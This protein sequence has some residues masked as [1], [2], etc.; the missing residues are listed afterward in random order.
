V[1][2]GTYNPSYPSCF[3]GIFMKHL[4][5]LSLVL[6]LAAC[7]TT[8]QPPGNGDGN[9]DGNGS[10]ER[11]LCDDGRHSLPVKAKPIEFGK[12]YEVTSGLLY[13]RA[14][15]DR[16]TKVTLRLDNMPDY[17]YLSYRVLNQRQQS[18]ITG[19]FSDLDGPIPSSAVFTGEIEEPGAVFVQ[20]E[21]FTEDLSDT[22][23]PR[24]QFTLFR[25]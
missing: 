22:R 2:R 7:G 11:P 8:T 15:T 10:S 23:C 18:V 19:H 16:P 9:G 4:I 5:Y 25:R 20:L 21:H 3:E 14:E 13:F 12:A 1:R 6:I 17:G 24:Y